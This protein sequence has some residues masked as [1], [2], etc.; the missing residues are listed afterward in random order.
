[1]KVKLTITRKGKIG[2]T[3]T[4]VVEIKDKMREIDAK[5]KAEFDWLY[6][7]VNRDGLVYSGDDLSKLKKYASV[8]IESGII[9]L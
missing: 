3:I 7:Y 8:S 5:K 4:R 9:E 1:M 2:G 6:E